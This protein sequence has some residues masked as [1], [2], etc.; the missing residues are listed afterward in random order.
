MCH[1]KK[2]NQ[3][4]I[5]YTPSVAWLQNCAD[6]LLW[7][8][9]A[10][11]SYLTLKGLLENTVSLAAWKAERDF[12]VGWYAASGEWLLRAKGAHN[13]NKKSC[14][15]EVSPQDV[16]LAH[17]TMLTPCLLFVLIP[18]HVSGLW[19]GGLS[20]IKI[21][22]NSLLTIHW[23]INLSLHSTPD[24]EFASFLSWDRILVMIYCNPYYD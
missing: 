22:A 4:Y 17:H 12:A 11:C 9:E 7:V 24:S 6:Y 20:V 13:S 10:L 15:Q 18:R 23:W 16:K 19:H 14:L 1:R 2:K 21:K 5:W 3:H 8:Q